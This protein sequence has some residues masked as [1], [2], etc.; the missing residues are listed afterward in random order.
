[1]NT[2]KASRGRRP[3]TRRRKNGGFKQVTAKFLSNRE[4]R[5]NSHL[6]NAFSAAWTVILFAGLLC[7]VRHHILFLIEGQAGRWFLLIQEV[8]ATLLIVAYVLA[9]GAGHARRG[10]SVIVEYTAAGVRRLCNVLDH[11]DDW[12]NRR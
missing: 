9:E 3:H 2:T 10:L 4:G 11:F 6:H 8:T 12:L 1:M 5:W 7:L